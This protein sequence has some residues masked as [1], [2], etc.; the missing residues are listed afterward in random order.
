MH[1]MCTS[2]RHPGSRHRRWRIRSAWAFQRQPRIGWPVAS[3]GLLLAD[4]EGRTLDGGLNPSKSARLTA[5]S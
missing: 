1:T 2:R 3:V 5:A 4:W